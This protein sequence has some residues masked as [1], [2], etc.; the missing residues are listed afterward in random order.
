MKKRLHNKVC[1]IT[2]S[3]GGIGRETALFFAKEGAKIV[4]CDVNEAA[5]LETEEM[6]IRAGGE[7]VSYLPAN[8]SNSTVCREVVGLALEAFGRIDVLFNNAARA[9]FN[10]LEDITDEEWHRNTA[11]EVDLVLFLTRAAWPHLKKTQGCVINTASVNAYVTFKTYGSIAHS[12][13]KAGILAMTRNMAKEG[14]AFQVRVN[15]ISP[16]IIA[17]NQTTDQLNSDKVWADDII[18]RTMLGRYGTPADIANA[19][20]FLASDE[21]NYIT[22]ADIVIDGGMNAW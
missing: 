5:G 12:T 22:G 21:S 14:S 9:Y 7:M 20:V 18:G 13:A 4:G 6:I 1:I 8:L 19:A 10:W 3:G 16:G 15:S 17:T 2:G 11:D